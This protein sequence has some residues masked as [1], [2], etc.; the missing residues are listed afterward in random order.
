[1]KRGRVELIN[2]AN[3]IIHAD[4]KKTPPLNSMLPFQTFTFSKLTFNGI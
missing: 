3:P 1:M 2:W 4:R